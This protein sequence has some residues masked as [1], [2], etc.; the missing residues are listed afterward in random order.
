MKALKTYMI[1]DIKMEAR[2]EKA[3]KKLIELKVH[4]KDIYKCYTEA[5][6]KVNIG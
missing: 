5:T 2:I 3:Y 4:R 1:L 6:E